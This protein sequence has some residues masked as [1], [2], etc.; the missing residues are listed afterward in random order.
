MIN[1]VKPRCPRCKIESMQEYV[2]DFHPKLKKCYIRT[3]NSNPL[4]HVGW[5]CDN[6]DSIFS[7]DINELK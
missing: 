5:Y 2:K 3:N 1:V 6:C 7:K 4:L